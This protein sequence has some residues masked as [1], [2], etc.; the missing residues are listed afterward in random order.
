MINWSF[1]E[2]KFIL[3]IMFDLP[4]K[5]LIIINLME[6]KIMNFIIFVSAAKLTNYT[7][8]VETDIVFMI[9]KQKLYFS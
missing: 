6:S 4:A 9:D 7:I 2:S 8:F 3:F 5:P 1:A